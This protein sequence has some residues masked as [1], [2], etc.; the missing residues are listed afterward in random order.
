MKYPDI[1]QIC[2]AGFLCF[3]GSTGL[4]ASPNNTNTSTVSTAP[5]APRALADRL[6]SARAPF[7]QNQGQIPQ[8]EVRFQARMFAGSLFVTERNQLVYAL[9]RH[10]DA[11]DRESVAPFWAFRESFSGAAKTQP[12]GE[13]ASAVRVSQFKGDRPAGWKPS[14]ATWDSLTLGELYP[15]IRVSL[16]ATGNN[17]EKLF[18]VAPGADA[19]TIDIAIEG[20]GGVR[21]DDNGQLV[22]GTTL[23][24]IVFTAPAAYQQVDGVRKPVKVA[25]TLAENGHYG[26]S[27]GDYDRSRELVIDPLL[28]STYL[29]G[30]NP[31]PPGNYDDDIIHGM[32]ASG[33]NVYVA[34]VTQSPDFPIVL[35]YDDTLPNAYPDGFIALLSGDLSTVI[36][37]TYIGTDSFDRVSDLA[38]DADGSVVVVGQAGYGFPVTAGAYTW[39]GST[40]TGG[41]FVARFSADLSTLLASSIPTPSD[42]PVRVELGNDGIYFGGTTT[43]PDFP[44][45]PGAFMDTCC[46]VGGFGI[47]ENDGFAGKLSS[48]MGTLEAMTYLGG[49]VV[50]GIS[51]APDSSVYITDGSDVAI[52]GYISRMDDGLTTRSAYLSYYP[53]STSGSSRTYFND[54]VAGDGFVVTAGQ[55]YM[56]DLPATPGA[57]D[58]TCGTDGLCDGVGPLLVPRADGFIAIYSADLQ[59]TLALTYFGGSDFE[60]IRSLKLGSDGSMF[61]TG[62]TTS[63]DFPT[64]GEGADT[65]CGSDGQCDPTG[66]FPTPANDGFV[67]RLSSDLS[68]LY[69]SSYLGGSGEDMPLVIALDDADRAYVAG[70]TRSRD[71]PTTPGAFDN[72]YNH[73]TPDGYVNTSDAFISLID[74]VPGG[75]DNLPPV[76][77]A[78][79][80][81]TVGPRSI[82]HLDGSGSSDP[83]GSIV[84]YHWTQVFGAK[85]K[86]I[87]E[88]MAVA[89]FRAPNVRSGMTRVL[90]FQLEVTDDQGATASD[91]VRIDVKR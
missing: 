24:D 66:R 73:D 43:N 40:P 35:G 76:A 56:N 39:S 26:F 25:Y 30:H 45:T 89:T 29:G 19:R 55:T 1:L 90:V 80:D 13:N 17:V 22:L 47:R 70:Y 37:S 3:A 23:G 71:F 36:A 60:S 49:D 63:V 31:N 2:F 53:G 52:T 69:Y 72:T 8:Q 65:A 7:I 67:A 81:Q 75:G 9:P 28:A 15:G 62:E 86:L 18:H 87:N 21:I 42:Y 44:I 5:L 38:L 88:G 91:Y 6:V 32:V 82:V 64:G 34:G 77:D 12:Q 20:V 79:S 14:L 51:V 4:N 46:P 61:V 11:A 54:V 33:G 68:Q 84:S 58:T 41:G 78:G 27:L 48:D 57:F 83:D 50:S 85:V 16:R 10:S 59:Q 74:A